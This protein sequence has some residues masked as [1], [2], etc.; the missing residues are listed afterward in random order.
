MFWLN[1]YFEM[2]LFVFSINIFV[3][4]GRLVI[5]LTYKPE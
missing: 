5:G 2:L 1:S 3:P 4:Q